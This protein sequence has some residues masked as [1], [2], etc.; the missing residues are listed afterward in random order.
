MKFSLPLG[1]VVFKSIRFRSHPKRID[2]RS[3]ILRSIRIHTTCTVSIRFRL[4][5]L[6]CSKPIEF[7]ILKGLKARVEEVGTFQSLFISDTSH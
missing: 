7:H 2:K 5:T 1:P 3:N 4:S 6:K